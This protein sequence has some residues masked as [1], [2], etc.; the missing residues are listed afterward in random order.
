MQSAEPET[1]P[2]KIPFSNSVIIMPEDKVEN[3]LMKIQETMIKT[4]YDYM[5]LA[6]EEYMKSLK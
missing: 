4:L 1:M 3:W 6:N 5:K 2:E